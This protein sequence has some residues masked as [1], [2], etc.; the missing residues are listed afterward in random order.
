MEQW[1]ELETTP[2]K[3]VHIDHKGPL[4]LSGN[5]NTHCPV[6]LDAFSRFLGAR[7]VRDTGA[8]TTINALEK[9]I[10]SY[11]IPQKIVHD[12]GSA[13]INSDFINWAKEFGITLA[14]RNTYSPSTN[15]KLEVQN[16]QLT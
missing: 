14:P 1:G 7:R 12:N 15:G 13:F 4:R 9:W 6:V 8:Q 5:S 3:T 10:T 11:D 2:L 16:Q